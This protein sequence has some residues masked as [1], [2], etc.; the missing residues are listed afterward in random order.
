MTNISASLVKDLREKTG[1]GMMDCKKALTE[2]QGDFEAAIDWLKK[3]GLAAAAKKSGR[4][5]AEGVTSVYV[6]GHKA[7]A[8]EINSETDFVSKNDIFLNFA[9]DVTK[10]AIHCNNIDELKQAKMSSGKTVEEELVDKIATIGENLTVRRMESVSV[11]NG[12]VVPYVHNAVSDSIGSIAVL[13]ALESK[14]DKDKLTALAKQLA[15]HIAAAR[16]TCLDVNS[17]DPAMVERERQIFIEQSRASGKPDNIIEKMTEGRIRKFFEEIVLL[18][19]VFVIDGKT[20]ISEVV[21]NLAKELG[22]A[23]ELKAYIRFEKG[24]GIEKTVTNFADEVAS[25]MQGN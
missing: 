1:A 23:V 6:E 8:V 9:K 17:V 11:N 18:E 2:T 10:A 14:G 24:E 12:V 19:Q 15:M 13:V 16:P 22:T 4:V 20:K 7:V 25:V 3:N 21:S 5:A